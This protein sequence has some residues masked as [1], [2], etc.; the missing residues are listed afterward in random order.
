MTFEIVKI[1]HDEASSRSYVHRPLLLALVLRSTYPRE[2]GFTDS[3]WYD[4]L[5]NPKARTYV[6][7]QSD[8]VICTLTSLGPLLRITEDLDLPIPIISP[9]AN[10]CE[11]VNGY[12]DRIPS[13]Y[14]LRI[15]GMF[16]L[17]KARGQ[18]V[19]KALIDRLVRDWSAEAENARKIF[20]ASLVVE[21]AKPA[22]RAL[23]EKCGF[24]TTGEEPFAD[25][26]VYPEHRMVL[27]MTYIKISTYEDGDAT[28]NFL[29]DVVTCAHNS[30]DN[31][32]D[33]NLLSTPLQLACMLAGSPIPDSAIQ[34]AE[35]QATSLATQ[36]TPTLTVVEDPANGGAEPKTTIY[37]LLPPVSTV[38]HTTTKSW[39]TMYQIYPITIRRTTISEPTS[40]FTSISTLISTNSSTGVG[41]I[42]IISTDS[43]GPTRTSTSTQPGVVSTYSTT[44]SQDST[45][46]QKSVLAAIASLS[47]HSPISL[48]SV[49]PKISSF[50]SN[51]VAPVRT[52]S[53]LLTSIKIPKAPNAD[54]TNSSPFK[55]TNGA[56][57]RPRGGSF[58]LGIALSVL[59]VWL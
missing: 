45:M 34:N 33:T 10:P 23:Y 8:A 55:N 20:A 43:E 26:T 14:P 54:E 21:K 16:I 39:S 4:R 30:C 5:A 46:T 58:G 35:N 44:D 50:K 57:G 37:T 38:T 6:A 18:G 36:V 24:V 32:F 51:S 1:P 15:N 41:P 9:L 12:E 13:E 48:T 22:A 49:V 28:E 29:T 53:I 59:Y 52:S 47:G 11:A 19:A 3:M 56:A 2:I 17:P 31:Y 40:K 25:C 42:V 7:L 27:L